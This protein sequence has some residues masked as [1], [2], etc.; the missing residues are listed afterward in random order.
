MLQEQ[1]TN[2]AFAAIIMAN[3]MAAQALKD[4]ATHTA[5]RKGN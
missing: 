1:L 2:E 5:A 4:S 3:I